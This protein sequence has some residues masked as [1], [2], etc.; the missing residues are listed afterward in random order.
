MSEE[1]DESLEQLENLEQAESEEQE[2]SGGGI[3]KWAFYIAILAGA[4]LLSYIFDWS[5]WIY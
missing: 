2:E 4:N 3:P 5:F 1:Q